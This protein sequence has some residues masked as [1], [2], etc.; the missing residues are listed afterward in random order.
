MRKAGLAIIVLV[1]G[2]LGVA[3]GQWYYHLFLQNMPPLALSTFN[4]GTAH[5]VFLGTGVALGVVIAIWTMIALWIAGRL[6]PARIA[7]PPSP[8]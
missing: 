8:K 4:Q 5:V 7:P 6:R 3:S 2:A 1:S